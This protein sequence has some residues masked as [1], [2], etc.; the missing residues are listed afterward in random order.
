MIRHYCRKDDRKENFM[1]I[2]T[3]IMWGGFIVVCGA[4]G[5][6]RYNKEYP[7]KKNK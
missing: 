5:L 4:V 2:I 7:P 6:A 3:A 1:E